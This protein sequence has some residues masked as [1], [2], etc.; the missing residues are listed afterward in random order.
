[1]I[2]KANIKLLSSLSIKKYRKRENLFL[3][4]GMRL[5][6]EVIK[7]NYPIKYIW[8]L[9]TFNDTENSQLLISEL[10]SRNIPIDEISKKELKQISDTQHSQGIVGI[11]EIPKNVTQEF[12]N[13]NLLL[14]DRISDPGNLGTMLR[15]AEWFGIKTVVLSEDC[16]DPY[17]PKIIR[18]AMGAHF[19]LNIVQKNLT[20]FCDK[21]RKK[22]YSVIAGVMNGQNLDDLEIS[23]QQNW[24]VVLGSEAHGI[25]ET[26]LSKCTHKVTIPKIGNLESLN[27]TTA[28]SILLYSLINK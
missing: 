9:D 12:C 4:E 17:S 21:L 2:S 23:I 5:F 8:V 6:T 13:Q 15:T 14:I 20:E 1:M 3:I 11:S 7:S 18:S 19:Y 22:Y 25:D 28:G 26:I 10:Q 27:V 24:D 16:A